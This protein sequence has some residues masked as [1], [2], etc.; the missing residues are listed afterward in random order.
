MNGFSRYDILFNSKIETTPEMEISLFFSNPLWKELDDF[1]IKTSGSKP[2]ISYNL[3]ASERHWNIEYNLNGRTLCTLYPV[4]NIFL[5]MIVIES[6]EESI[7]QEL[8]PALSKRIQQLFENTYKTPL[9]RWLVVEV[10][11]K[12]NLYDVKLMLEM[13]IKT[14]DPTKSKVEYVTSERRPPKE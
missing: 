8:L 4:K 11:D 2:E 12:K 7:I 13:C 9:G 1:I 6:K 3:C 5:A 14:H 10:S